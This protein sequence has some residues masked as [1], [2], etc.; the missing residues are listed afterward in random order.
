[1]APTGY[2]G[3]VQIRSEEQQNP[4]ADEALAI[5]AVVRPILTG[6]LYSLK[7]D[8]VAEAGGRTGVKLKM[9]PRLRRPGD[10]DTGIC[11]EYAVH[12]AV[13]PRRWRCRGAS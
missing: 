2:R 12:D 9:L 10:G 6:I 3:D 7:A 8:V 5:T 4:V 11:F 13:T 1:M